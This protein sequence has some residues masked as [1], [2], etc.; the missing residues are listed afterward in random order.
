MKFKTYDGVLD[1]KKMPFKVR[2]AYEKYF[3]MKRRSG[4]NF[5]VREFIGWWLYN[6]KRFKGVEPSIGRLDHSKGY[7]FDNIEI[8]EMSENSREAILRNKRHLKTAEEFSRPLAMYDWD[9]NTFIGYLPSIRAAAVHFGV[10]Q[11]LIQFIV[12]GKYKSSKKVPYRLEYKDGQA[13]AS[14]SNDCKR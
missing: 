2:L 11:R 12:R 7:S 6:L 13:D 5:S 10:S 4:V 14:N 9:N 8:Q 1:R 3:G